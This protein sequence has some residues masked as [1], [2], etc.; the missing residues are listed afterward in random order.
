MTVF[1]PDCTIVA[2]ATVTLSTNAMR[3]FEQAQVSECVSSV[4]SL[5]CGTPSASPKCSN[6]AVLLRSLSGQRAG[7]PLVVSPRVF[8]SIVVNADW[9]KKHCFNLSHC[10]PILSNQ[11]IGR[12]ICQTLKLPH[13]PVGYEMFYRLRVC[14]LESPLRPFLHVLSK[15]SFSRIDPLPRPVQPDSIVW[16]YQPDKMV[17]AALAYLTAAAANPKRQR[18]DGNA[19]C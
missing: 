5:P 11:D 4:S 16:S 6:P 19:L 1:D 18:L 8:P 15:S 17:A 12:L 9:Q 13:R 3:A 10:L 14:E 7:S 2:G